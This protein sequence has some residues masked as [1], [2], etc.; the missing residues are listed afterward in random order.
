ML[1]IVNNVKSTL[2]KYFCIN[3][4]YNFAASNKQTKGIKKH[5]NIY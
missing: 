2:K 4:F 5:F 1:K 3:F